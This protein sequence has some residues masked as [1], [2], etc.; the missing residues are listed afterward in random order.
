[1]NNCNCN[2]QWFFSKPPPRQQQHRQ[3]HV[4]ARGRHRRWGSHPQA[5]HHPAS[6]F[7]TLDPASL[8]FRLADYVAAATKNGNNNNPGIE[9]M[10]AAAC[11][12]F[13]SSGPPPGSACV[14]RPLSPATSPTCPRFRKAVG[15]HGQHPVPV[16]RH[17]HQKHLKVAAG[18]FL[19]QAAPADDGPA[20]QI[21]RH[22]PCSACG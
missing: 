7:K 20:C 22:H 3:Q 4:P 12:G 9:F 19:A 15:N 18:S 17:H 6:L 1:M 5:C 13:G 21:P 2:T 8:N 16:A 10:L 11:P 14:S